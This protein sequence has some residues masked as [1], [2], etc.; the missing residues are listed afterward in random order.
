MKIR[1][2]GAELFHADRVAHITKLTVAFCNFVYAP[3]NEFMT[4][5]LR[6]QMEFR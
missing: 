5:E 6:K 1:P 4:V 3:K 2:L